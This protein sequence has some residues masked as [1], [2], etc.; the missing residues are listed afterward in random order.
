MIPILFLCLSYFSRYDF[1]NYLIFG[2]VFEPAPL[3]IKT[4]IIKLPEVAVY[5]I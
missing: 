1:F 5:N 3:N 2:M 4:K